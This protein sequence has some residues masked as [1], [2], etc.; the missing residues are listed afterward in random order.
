MHGGMH[1]GSVGAR[2]GEIESRSMGRKGTISSE[3]KHTS[4]N[5]TGFD[6]ISSFAGHRLRTLGIG[7][8]FRRGLVPIARARRESRAHFSSERFPFEKPRGLF[9]GASRRVAQRWTVRRLN[10]VPVESLGDGE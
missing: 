4:A 6:L 5:E 2:F 1:G 7:R 8:S 9:Y 3:R 10:R